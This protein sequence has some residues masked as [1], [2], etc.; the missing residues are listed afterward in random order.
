MLWNDREEVGNV[1]GECEEDEGTDCEMDA[2]KNKD[3]ES[4]EKR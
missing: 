2:M 3:G 1:S 4:D